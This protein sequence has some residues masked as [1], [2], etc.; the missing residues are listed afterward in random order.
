[1]TKSLSIPES[2]VTNTPHEVWLRGP[3]EGVAPLLQPV[4]HALLQA[5]EETDALMQGFPDELLFTRPDSVASVGFHLQHMAGVLDRLTT[6]A[7]GDALSAAQ[8]AALHGAGSAPPDGASS[9]ALVHDFRERVRQTVDYLRQVPE[10]ALTDARVVGRSA[11][12]STVI[13]L[14]VHCAEH[15]MRH[16]GQLLVTSRVLR[17]RHGVQAEDDVE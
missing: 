1:M 10:S 15:T 7:R 9:A 3:V 14:L 13:G 17:E 2:I 11:L 6:Y 12:P 5:A 16:L 4:V 8:L